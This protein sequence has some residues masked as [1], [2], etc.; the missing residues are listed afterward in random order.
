[1]H[2]LQGVTDLHGRA[3]IAQMDI[4]RFY[5][6]LPLLR[7]CRSL[8]SECTE[9]VLAI[10]LLRLHI[11]PLVHLSFGEASVTFPVRCVGALTGTRTAGILGRV[12]FED[13]VRARHEVWERFCFKSDESLFALAVYI[14]NIFSTGR[15]ADGA[16]S[17]LQDFEEHLKQRWNQTIG[18]DSKSF[19]CARGCTPP[20]HDTAALAHS[21]GNTFAALGHILAY[22]GQIEPCLSATIASM[23]RSFYGNFGKTLK[24]APISSKLGLLGRA[25]L[26]IA[27]HRMS[28]WPYQLHAAKRIDRTQ[29]KMIR[30]LMR[31]QFQPGDDFASFA[32]RRNRVAAGVARRRGQWSSV[33][34][35]RVVDWD[36][37]L[38]RERNQNSWAAKALKYHG[39]VWLQEQ[40]RIHAVGEH[41]SV[42][43]GRTRTRASRGIVHRRWHDGVEAAGQS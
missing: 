34:R 24:D 30:A 7:I 22:D 23:W 16:M 20:H 25:V 1:M 35:K 28:R 8:L 29:T 6:S 4:R 11:C 12:P 40:R 21:H 33:W 9:Q 10:S 14:D 37:H 3:A 2:G 38:Q 15:D 31:E 26:P 43:A 41:S 13:V 39:K 5:D 19:L 42:H 27:T 18:E 17:I 32:A 36:A